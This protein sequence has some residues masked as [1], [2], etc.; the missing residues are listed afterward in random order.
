MTYTIRE[1]LSI[2][3]YYKEECKLDS[4]CVPLNAV[5]CNLRDYCSLKIREITFNVS[6]PYRFFRG[7]KFGAN[8]SK[9][10]K[11]I[12]PAA[13]GEGIDNTDSVLKLTPSSV[14]LYTSNIPS[15]P[16]KFYVCDITQ[17]HCNA[18]A[19]KHFVASCADGKHNLLQA[20]N[21]IGYALNVAEWIQ[22]S[23]IDISN[24]DTALRD[25]KFILHFS[26][27]KLLEH[28]GQKLSIYTAS[29]YEIMHDERYGDIALYIKKT[30]LQHASRY[31]VQNSKGKE[32]DCWN[33]KFGTGPVLCHDKEDVP[34][35]YGTIGYYLRWESLSES[36][37][38]AGEDLSTR[39][40]DEL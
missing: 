1:R 26:K 8:L 27:Y 35:D 19:Q 7:T 2:T 23:K 16:F 6:D 28:D 18:L 11:C 17:S 31:G 5:D 21:C 10:E 25:I 3:Q 37:Q 20:Y 30:Q 4:H 15:T 40:S 9:Q 14:T 38:S 12:L 34:N 36:I 22:P 24:K 29:E 13:I 32:I 33:S 39:D